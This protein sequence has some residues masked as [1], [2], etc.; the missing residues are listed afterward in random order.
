MSEWFTYNTCQVATLVWRIQW[1]VSG[2]WWRCQ[3]PYRWQSSWDIFWKLFVQRC[4]DMSAAIELITLIKRLLCGEIWCRAGSEYWK[5]T[6]SVSDLY[7]SPVCPSL[8]QLTLIVFY[9]CLGTWWRSHCW[10]SFSLHLDSNCEGFVTSHFCHWNIFCKVH[11]VM[12]IEAAT[13][14]SRHVLV[15]N[16]PLLSLGRSDVRS[17][18]ESQHESR[19]CEKEVF[20]KLKFS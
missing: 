7:S 15:K 3:A 10:N 14:V 11:G 12:G 20:S 17:V 13:R 19:R 4:R 5:F 2:I 9:L 18:M 6:V 8:L 16:C 1:P